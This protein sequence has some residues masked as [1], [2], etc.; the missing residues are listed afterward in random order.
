MCRSG[1][2]P[3]PELRTCD[4]EDLVK[5]NRAINSEVKKSTDLLQT[6]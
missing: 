3:E 4:T 2:S 5:I 1:G 6:C